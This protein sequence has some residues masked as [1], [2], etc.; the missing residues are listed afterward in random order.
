MGS[1]HRQVVILVPDEESDCFGS[2]RLGQ[3]GL[4]LYPG[5]TSTIT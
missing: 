4:A 1:H 5:G 2:A 3:N